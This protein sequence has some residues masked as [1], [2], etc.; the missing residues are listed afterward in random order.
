MAYNA[1]TTSRNNEASLRVSSQIRTIPRTNFLEF[2]T[3]WIWLPLL[4]LGV[5]ALYLS[6]LGP[7]FL[8]G[9]S[10]ETITAG[11]TLGVQ[12]P[13]GY[14]LSAL[15]LRLSCLL[16]VGGPCFQAALV[17]TL[18]ASLAAVL[19][20]SNL[21][22][23][24]GRF[25]EE[26]FSRGDPSVG[27]WVL[28]LCATLG[29]L[30]LA[31]SKTFWELALSAKGGVYLLETVLL[32]ALFRCALGREAAP[33]SLDGKNLTSPGVRWF[34]PAFFLVRGR[35]GPSLA[36]AVGF[37]P[38]APD[39]LPQT[40]G[41]KTSLAVPPRGPSFSRRVCSCWVFPPSSIFR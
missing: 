6:T 41:G 7:A 24:L 33:S 20:A 5:F 15:I 32:L 38:P 16:P 35:I 19:L 39:L 18:L 22:F 37:F 17:S 8:D 13:P 23:L 36:D 12:H 2:F 9:D 14:A 40:T 4:F 21:R 3:A 30:L 10:P 11:F 31:C 25:F 28:L 26:R 29:A 27:G 34:Y 1:R